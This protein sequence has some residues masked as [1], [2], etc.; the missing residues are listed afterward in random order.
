MAAVHMGLKEMGM[1]T[2]TGQYNQPLSW[3]WEQGHHADTAEQLRSI[4]TALDKIDWKERGLDLGFPGLPARWPANEVDMLHNCHVMTHWSQNPRPWG[5]FQP[6]FWLS[7]N[8]MVW[9]PRDTVR[10]DPIWSRYCSGVLGR[11]LGVNP[12]WQRAGCVMGLAL[13]Q[14]VIITQLHKET[15]QPHFKMPTGKKSIKT[16]ECKL[17]YDTREDIHMQPSSTCTSKS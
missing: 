15:P 17:E 16:L 13:E 5:T 14:I 2:G 9:D 6:G 11:V 10:C 12:K 8:A 7:V 3:D 1:Q 4:S